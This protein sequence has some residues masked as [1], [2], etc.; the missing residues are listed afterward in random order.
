MEDWQTAIEYSNRSLAILREIGDM[1]HMVD[2]HVNLGLA[3]LGRGCSDQAKQQ[4]EEALQL[5]NQTEG[6]NVS[7][8]AENRGRALRLLGETTRLQGN[9][10]G[11][12]KLLKEAAT[13]FVGVGNQL[14]QSRS[15]VSMAMLALSRGDQ[16]G[17]RV[18]FNEARLIFRQL[19]A[20]LDLQKLEE[21]MVRQPN[22][23][24]SRT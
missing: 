8:Q 5:I 10:E 12:E 11:A 13:L 18:L 4:G 6:S 3:W 17:A 16:V 15:A 1:D 20:N 14:E 24:R 2:V 23:L 21:L 19:G 7:A 22:S 9:Y